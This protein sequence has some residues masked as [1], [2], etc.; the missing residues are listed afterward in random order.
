MDIGLRPVVFIRFNP[1][2]YVT[3]GGETV[4]S[5][6]G[7]DSNGVGRVKLSK[8]GEWAARLTALCAEVEKWLQAVPDRE[9]T[10]VQLFYDE[11][12]DLN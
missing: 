4:T 12:N 3:S 5:C 9:F 11:K 8:R 2:A 1:D 10:I 6:W 7:V